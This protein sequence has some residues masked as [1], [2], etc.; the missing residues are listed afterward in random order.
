MQDIMIAEKKSISGGGSA[1]SNERADRDYLLTLYYECQR[2]VVS[3][4]APARK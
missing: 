2:V 4:V 1:S 3:G